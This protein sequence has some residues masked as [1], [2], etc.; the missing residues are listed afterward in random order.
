MSD[1]V[2]PW[3]G[4]CDTEDARES[5]INKQIVELYRDGSSWED[6][7][8]DFD[9]T[10]QEAVE[11]YRTE[12]WDHWTTGWTR[13][14]SGGSAHIESGV[15]QAP[16]DADAQIT[17]EEIRD[18]IP[19]LVRVDAGDAAAT[20]HAYLTADGARELARTLEE[21]ADILESNQE[22]EAEK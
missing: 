5:V 21:C 16:I 10:R 7:A 11:R 15:L 22:R 1:S 18:E 19:L 9:I 6:I 17:I 4:S 2:L 8:D 13:F 20:T 12:A 3:R 14:A